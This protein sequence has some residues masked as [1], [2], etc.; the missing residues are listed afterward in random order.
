MRVRFFRRVA[1]AAARTSQ[2]AAAARR[3]GSLPSG[4]MDAE[5]ID[6]DVAH[7]CWAA[8][9]L[10]VDVRLPEE[11][12]RGHIA[13]AINLPLSSIPVRLEELPPGQ[14]ITV[15]SMG[16]RSRLG[17]DVFA[18]HG[19]T[20]LSMRGGV[21]AWQRAG[22]P[23]VTGTEPGARSGSNR[24]SLLARLLRRR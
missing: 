5:E 15:C 20:A 1:I 10:V 11:Y 8:G 3:D 16:N 7:A 9:D 21:K 24:P 13:G 14:I 4:H 18:R 22:L 19:R 17:A 2:E 6:L 23:V 12:A